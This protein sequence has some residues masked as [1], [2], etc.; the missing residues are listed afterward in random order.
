MP[1]FG[2]KLKFIPEPPRCVQLERVLFLKSLLGSLFKVIMVIVAWEWFVRRWWLRH[3][4]WPA[5]LLEQALSTVGFLTV[6]LVVWLILHVKET[7]W[8]EELNK[9]NAD[10][11]EEARR[12]TG[13]EHV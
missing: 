3:A 12:G 7:R 2:D 13:R 1:Y 9:L 11:R 8:R 4:I 6:S 5:G 10:W